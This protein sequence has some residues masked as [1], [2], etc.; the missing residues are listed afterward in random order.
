[1]KIRALAP[2]ASTPKLIDSGMS[3]IAFDPISEHRLLES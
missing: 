2:N 1:M 3:S